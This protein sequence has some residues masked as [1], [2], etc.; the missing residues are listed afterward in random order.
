MSAAANQS[1]N[2]AKIKR[3]IDGIKDSLADIIDAE[4]KPRGAVDFAGSIAADVAVLACTLGASA[5]VPGLGQAVKS[6]VTAG[7]NA[8][9]RQMHQLTPLEALMTKFKGVLMEERRKRE[10][11][12]RTRTGLEGTLSE[13]AYFLVG[14][15]ILLEKPQLEDL[16]KLRRELSITRRNSGSVRD[17]IML[18]ASNIISKLKKL[19]HVSDGGKRTRVMRSRRQ[20]RSKTAKSQRRR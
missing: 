15:F 3:N 16:E 6:A 13:K 17:K 9:K 14:D 7:V 20:L 12:E 1:S 19:Q 11:A 4:P 18:A 10:Q 5:A 8:C 2:I